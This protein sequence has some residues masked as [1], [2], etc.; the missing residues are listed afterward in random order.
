MEI[1]S[2]FQQI[3]S[4]NINHTNVTAGNLKRR[5]ININVG[6]YVI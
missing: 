1:T 6:D 3:Q 4:T 2:R 5:N